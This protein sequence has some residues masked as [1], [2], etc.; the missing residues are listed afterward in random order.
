M[1]DLNFAWS[2]NEVG[3]SSR[4]CDPMADYFISVFKSSNL[5]DVSPAILSPTWCNGRAGR[6]SIAKRLDRFIL[7]DSLCSS[8]GKYRSWNHSSGVSNHRVVILQIYFDKSFINHPFKFNPT[9]LKEDEFDELIRKEWAL[10]SDTVLRS[11]SPVKVFLHKL[12]RIQPV[13]RL[14]EKTKKKSLISDICR[15]EYD[16]SSIEYHLL[17]EPGS[18][19]L[20]GDLK[21]FLISRGKLLLHK[22]ETLRKKSQATWLLTGEENTR[23]FHHFTNKRWVHNSVWEAMDGDNCT[24]YDQDSIRKVARNYFVDLYKEPDNYTIE[25]QLG[26]INISPSYVSTEDNLSMF[27][28]VLLSEVESTLKIFAKDKSPELDD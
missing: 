7:S 1:G 28:L 27:G 3:G 2:S 8:F 24:V 6:L 19:I 18:N 5:Q 15:L 13:V 11:T 9:W 10:M 21:N 17:Y 12:R 16:I 20:Q 23:Y 14:W 4:P 25:D 26:M 22:E